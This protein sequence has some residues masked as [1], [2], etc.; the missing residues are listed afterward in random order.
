[1]MAYG[2]VFNALEPMHWTFSGFS[3]FF[4][5]T[6]SPRMEMAANREKT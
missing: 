2:I 6:R 1:M 4:K 3:V 5:T